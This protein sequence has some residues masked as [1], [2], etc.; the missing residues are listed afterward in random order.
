MTEKTISEIKTLL[1][2]YK[3]TGHKIIIASNKLHKSYVW[4]N[5][6]KEKHNKNTVLH[7]DE[8][9]KL[10]IEYYLSFVDKEDIGRI[11]YAI[12]GQ[13]ILINELDVEAIYIY[14][15]N[16]IEKLTEYGIWLNYDNEIGTK[17]YHPQ[18]L[19][20]IINHLDAL[21]KICKVLKPI[22]YSLTANTKKTEVC[23]INKYAV[24]ASELGKYINSL[25]KDSILSDR[26]S[27]LLCDILTESRDSTNKIHNALEKLDAINKNSEY[28]FHSLIFWRKL[29]NI[30]DLD[31]ENCKDI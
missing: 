17:L 1:K 3:D 26:F 4:F 6:G 13:G 7:H 15:I 23:N 25:D 21:D 31:N 5:I 9:C 10:I 19:N 20:S 18:E 24:E 8:V 11:L 29:K 16:S 14:D 2:N 27:K 12:E 22:A 30:L 28:I